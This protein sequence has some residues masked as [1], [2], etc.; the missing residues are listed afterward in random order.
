MK[1]VIKMEYQTGDSFGSRD[2]TGYVE[3]SWENLEIAKEN[4]QRIKEHYQFYRA[5]NDH[6]RRD[7]LEELRKEAR[8]KSWYCHNPGIPYISEERVGETHVVL[9]LDNGAE[10]NYYTGMWCGYFERLR[11]AEIVPEPGSDS[12]MYISFS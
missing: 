12:D 6:F 8:E 5:S 11:S 9:K 1:Y 4:L 7:E 10:F 3:L 2:E